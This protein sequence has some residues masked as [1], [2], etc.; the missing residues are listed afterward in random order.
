MERKF[1]SQF[2]LASPQSKSSS[3]AEVAPHLSSPDGHGT[4]TCPYGTSRTP[5][6][7]SLPA[8]SDILPPTVGRPDEEAQVIRV[9]R[10][11][12]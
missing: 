11:G 2:P 7:G 3:N 6:S 4:R 5:K 12:P 1:P 9:E 10:P 8:V